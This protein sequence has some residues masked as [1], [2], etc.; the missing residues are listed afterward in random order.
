MWQVGAHVTTGDLATA[1]MW[2][3]GQDDF[4][5]LCN[6]TKIAADL[7]YETSLAVANA[8]I[9]GARLISRAGAT[10][11]LKWQSPVDDP[12]FWIGRA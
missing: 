2:N 8:P 3:A 7:V 9:E 5:F 11:G 1:A 4:D 6:G 10:G 12:M